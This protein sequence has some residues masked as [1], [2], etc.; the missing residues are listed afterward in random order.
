MHILKDERKE[1]S[2]K[3]SEYRV[4]ENY[5]VI[6]SQVTNESEILSSEKDRILFVDSGEGLVSIEGQE[7]EVSKSDVLFVPFKK[8][9]TISGDMRLII[10]VASPK[11]PEE[12]E[13]EEPELD[14]T[15]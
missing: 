2:V 15:D 12:A 1:H 13:E 5:Q 11:C 7:Y 8:E 6:V 3:M 10:F 9:A 4:N 14:P